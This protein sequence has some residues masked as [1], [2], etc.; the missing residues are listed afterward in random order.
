MN[1][2]LSNKINNMN[3]KVTHTH[4]QQKCKF[5]NYST[6]DSKRVCSKCIAEHRPKLSVGWLIFWGLLG[7]V[8]AIIYWFIKKNE[9][10]Q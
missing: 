9:Q 8:P 10:E 3:V 2:Q 5:C 4:T 6:D 7:L 1:I